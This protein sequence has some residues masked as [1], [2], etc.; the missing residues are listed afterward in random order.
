M[1]QDQKREKRFMLLAITGMEKNSKKPK[2]LIAGL[3]NIVMRDDGAGVHAVRE[4]VKH[5]IEGTKAVEVGC[6]VFDSLHLLEAADWILLID[7]M[8]AGGPPGSVYLCDLS[9]IDGRPGQGSLH[10]LSIITAL[11]SFAKKRASVIKLVGIEP[12][13]ID[14][15]LE[16]SDA[17]QGALP[18]VY[19]LACSITHE[20]K[21][22]IAS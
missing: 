8:E 7:A 13:V 6:A 2:I 22:A 15:G 12:A 17:V 5:P 9:D 18:R 3:G 20:W 11:Q 16:L 14:Y 10:H 21:M 19:Q 4:L 1:L